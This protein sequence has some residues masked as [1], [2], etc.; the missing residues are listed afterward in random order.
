MTGLDLVQNAPTMRFIAEEVL[1]LMSQ[2]TAVLLDVDGTLIDSNDAHAK[3]WCDA[4]SQFGRHA[5]FRDIRSLIG[6]GGDKLLAETTGLSNERGIGKQVVELRKKIFNRDY[7]PTLRPFPRSFELVRHMRDR[8]LKLA[9]ATSATKQEMGALLDVI[10]I[11]DLID[12]QTSSDDADRSK[13]DPDILVVA[14]QQLGVSPDDAVMLGDTPY[15]VQAAERTKV[16]TIALL[17][18]GWDAGA[19]APAVAIYRDCAELLEKFD[20]SPLGRR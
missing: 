6:K 4:L 19:L 9:V 16:R 13:P 7:L 5:D 11:S 17:S 18:G 10:G 3:S 20:E 2:V 14:L 1:L 12:V 8:G 15:D